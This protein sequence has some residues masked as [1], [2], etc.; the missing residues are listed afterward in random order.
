MPTILKTKNSVTTTV[1]P[2]TLQQGEL[3]VNITDRKMWVGNAATTPVQLF[4]AGADGSFVNLAYT[5][6]LTGG[7]GI[8]NLG[9][10]QFYKDASGNIGLGVTT[11]AQKLQ[12]GNGG[13]NDYIQFAATNQGYVMGRENATGEFLWNATQASPFNVFKWQQGGTERMRL[14]P[15][16]NLGIGTTN[17]TSKLYVEGSSIQ[18]RVGGTGIQIYGDGGAG[19][20]NSIGANPLIL[21]V[22]S[23]ER[24]RITSAGN[25]GIGDSSPA[26]KLTVNGVIYAYNTSAAFLSQDTTG[27]AWFANAQA[28]NYVITQSG[29]AERMRI[30][31]A[32]NVGIGTTS[33]TGRLNA[34]Q[35]GTSTTAFFQNTNASW[36]ADVTTSYAPSGT[37]VSNFGISARSDATTW[38]TSSYGAMILRTG[39]SGSAT[40]KM[41]LATNGDVYIARS[42]TFSYANGKVCIDADG[43]GNPGLVVG[44]DSTSSAYNNIVLGNSTGGV[45]R[46]QTNGSATAYLTSSDYRL[47]KD[48]TP[49]ENAIA[50]IQSL[51]PVAFTWNVDDR[52]DAGFL[53]HEFQK[54]LPNYADGTKDGVDSN[55]NPAY[56]AVDKSGVI[57]YLVKAMQEQQALIENLTT[58][59]NALEGK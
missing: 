44:V 4:G 3:A 50:T 12:V 38:L 30:D 54:I 16:G 17:P 25:V 11:P 13:V 28:G 46:I 1:V 35:T 55:G 53:A 6:T 51:N 43:S 24:M 20:V 21:Q 42:S 48:V 27:G 23:S 2:T 49:I 22:N 26:Y 37:E 5:G 34:V 40:E 8:V 41:R 15:S 29:V 32:G 7:T 18:A 31:S 10:G 19:Y 14:D 39:T 45:G 52:Q 56:Q 33:M 9:S 57:P 36:A 59:L 58:R 47:K